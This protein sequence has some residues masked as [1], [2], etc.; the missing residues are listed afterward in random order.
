M[1]GSAEMR[2][3]TETKGPTETKHP[4]LALIELDSVA[5]GIRAADTM[6]KRAPISLLK[7]GTVHPGRYLVMV[8]GSVASVGEAWKAGLEEG[9]GFL[10]DDVFLPDVHEQVLEGALGRTAQI[11]EEALGVLE[12]HGVAAL[13]R[14]ADAG[15]KGA[16]VRIA[17]MRLADGLGGRAFVLFDGPLPEVEAALE[18]GA[19]SIPEERVLHRS[20]LPRLDDNLRRLLGTSTRFSA[21]EAGEPEGAEQ[22]PSD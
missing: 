15:V 12:T 14:A 19:S 11:E 20:I 5:A 16:A 13:L 21:C 1:R 4:A 8:G 18:I 22:P 2:N 3:P 7:V 17:E 9:R 6:V 10:I